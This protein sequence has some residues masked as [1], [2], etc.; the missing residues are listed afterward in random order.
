M[1]DNQN[2]KK[3]VD[4]LLKNGIM[5]AKDVAKIFSMSLK[6]FYAKYMG[7]DTNV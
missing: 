1:N 5:E 6:E 3:L 4:Y 2:L 7:K